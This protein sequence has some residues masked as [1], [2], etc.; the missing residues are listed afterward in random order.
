MICMCNFF[1]ENRE[2][3]DEPNNLASMRECFV[4]SR[5]HVFPKDFVSALNLLVLLNC[6]C[7]CIASYSDFHLPQN[8]LDIFVQISLANFF[9]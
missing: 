7:C 5:V 8:Q 6:I 3:V 2:D 4:C 9:R 1:T